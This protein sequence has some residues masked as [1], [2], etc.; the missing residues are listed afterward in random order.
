MALRKDPIHLNDAGYREA[1]IADRAG[2]WL[3]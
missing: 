2:T 1:A 3:R